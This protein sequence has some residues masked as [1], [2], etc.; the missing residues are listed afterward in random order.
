MAGQQ[1]W[2]RGRERRRKTGKT[3]LIALKQD[4]E[5]VGTRKFTIFGI[6]SQMTS[7]NFYY[8][9]ESSGRGGWWFNL[10]VGLFKL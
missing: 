9:E 8:V 2:R 7:W 5:K 6:S 10:Q 4:G 3:L 1:N